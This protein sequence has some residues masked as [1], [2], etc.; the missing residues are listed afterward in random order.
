V[1]HSQPGRTVMRIDLPGME[2]VTATAVRSG[3]VRI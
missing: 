2:T 1:E 3:S